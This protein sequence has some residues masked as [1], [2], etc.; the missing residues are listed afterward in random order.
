MRLGGLNGAALCESIASDGTYLPTRRVAGLSSCSA[1][2]CH[3]IFSG[4]F[5][6]TGLKN[7]ATALSVDLSEATNNGYDRSSLRVVVDWILRRTGGGETE[8]SLVALR[9][10]KLGVSDIVDS[11][12]AAGLCILTASV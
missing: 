1:L 2:S 5:S 6:D 9:F 4:G 3:E 10:S 8:P 12:L 11:N 7:D